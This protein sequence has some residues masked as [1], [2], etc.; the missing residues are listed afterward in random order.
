MQSERKLLFMKKIVSCL[1][2]V[3][4]LL[5]LT[6]FSSSADNSAASADTQKVVEVV[7]AQ[8][9]D[10]RES[11]DDSAGVLP[12][13]AAERQADGTWLALYSDADLP[14]DTNISRPADGEVRYEK[15]VENWRAHFS[16]FTMEFAYREFSDTYQTWC[17]GN[18]Q[19]QSTRKSGSGWYAVYKGSLSGSI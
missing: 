5:S 17:S 9:A 8:Y 14:L 13:R 2:S 3:V 7:F 10:I 19:L 18:L 12:L 6:A 15:T 1:L 4:L 11:V 16:E